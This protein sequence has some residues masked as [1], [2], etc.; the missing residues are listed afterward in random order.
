MKAHRLTGKSYAKAI[1]VGIATAVILSAVMLLGLKTGISPLPKPLALAFANTLL[2][3]D[4][5]LPVGLLFHVAW[6]TLW[7]VV[8]VVLFWDHLGFGR[9]LALGLVLWLLVLVAFFPYVGWGFLGLDAGT[10]V[11]VAALMQHVL[12]ALVL[13]ALARSAFGGSHRVAHG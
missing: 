1:G 5:P 3:A 8:Y 7:S 10:L 6:V 9:A 13:W 11:P 2:G 4:L 12:F